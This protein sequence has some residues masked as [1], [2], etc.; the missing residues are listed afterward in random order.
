MCN[1]K[2]LKSTAQELEEYYHAVN[3]YLGYQPTFFENAYDHQATPIV[4]SERKG[5]LIGALWGFIPSTVKTVDKAKELRVNTINAR[6]EDMYNTPSYQNSAK[7]SLR[8][9]IPC[10]GFYESHHSPDS[11]IKTPYII[12]VKNQPIFSLAGIYSHW[13][14]PERNSEMITYS[15]CTTAANKQMEFVHNSKK[16]QPVFIP[17]E[18]EKDYLNGDLTPEDVIELC[19]SHSD[20]NFV[21]HPV[22]KTVNATKISSSEKNVPGIDDPVNYTI[23]EME[24]KPKK[25]TGSLF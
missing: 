12:R 20:D 3:R 25:Q 21:Y 19:R 23:E 2:Q 11:K 4:T 18:Y 22:S 10:T 5:E 16:R 14:H 24:G 13:H 17:R 15:I 1:K 8:C 6:S 9:L 7:A